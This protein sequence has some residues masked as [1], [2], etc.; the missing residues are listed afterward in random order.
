[1]AN[2]NLTVT[3]ELVGT[4]LNLSM[5]LDG[6]AQGVE[7]VD[8]RPLC[9]LDYHSVG[10]ANLNTTIPDQT[11]T[12]VDGYNEIYFNRTMGGGTYPNSLADASTLG[13]FIVQNSGVYIIAGY[14][15][16]ANGGDDFGANNGGVRTMRFVRDPAGTPD[17][18]GQTDRTANQ[19]STWQAHT[20]VNRLSAG[21]PIGMEVWQNSGAPLDIITAQLK[22]AM[23]SCA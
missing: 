6:V 13:T 2:C 16:W 3:H 18:T 19:G 7:T 17:P 5:A 21:T 8:L 1:M 11:W 4:D 12:V 23:M 14:A 20:W 22:I 15:R 9:V 10:K